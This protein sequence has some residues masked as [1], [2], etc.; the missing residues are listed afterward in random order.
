VRELEWFGSM[1]RRPLSV[2][3]VGEF[4]EEEVAGRIL[5]GPKLPAHNRLSIYRQQYW[6]RFFRLM[7]T[8]FP[9]I[10]RLFSSHPLHF[11]LVV[12]YV[13]AHP[14]H[15]WS[16]DLLGA[17][18]PG[19]LEAT[20]EGSDKALVVLAAQVDWAI[21]EGPTQPELPAVTLAQAA[22]SVLRLQ[23]HVTLW[24]MPWVFPPVRAQ[25]IERPVD[26]WI[27]EPFPKLDRTE[28]WWLLGRSPEGAMTWKRLSETQYLL[29]KTL[30]QG[31]T[32]AQALENIPE[33]ALDEAQAGITAWFMEWQHNGWLTV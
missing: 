5:P 6:L 19:W 22:T 33:S 27:D 7:E 26:G 25:I 30:S 20:Y 24:H 18:F 29:L 16:I 14:P 23:P 12:P 2:G 28:C 9:T 15:A 13:Q 31:A 3:Y 8:C 17:Q 4:T 21:Y 10:A 11:H 1:I 32:L